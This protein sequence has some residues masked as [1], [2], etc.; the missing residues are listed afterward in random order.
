VGGSQL[1]LTVATLSSAY[2]M[3]ANC[4]AYGFAGLSAGAAHL[5]EAFGNEAVKAMFVP[6][7]T[8][9]RWSGTMALTEPQAGSSLAGD[10][11][12]GSNR[13]GALSDQRRE[14]LHFGW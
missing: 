7:M 1:P 4:S 12:S 13:S 10:L 8:E 5:I 3:A 2:L 14:D 11:A 6:A 9:G